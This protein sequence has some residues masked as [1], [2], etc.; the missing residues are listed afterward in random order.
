MSLG[1]SGT[2]ASFLI[3]GNNT[4]DRYSI[5]SDRLPSTRSMPG[6]ALG[7]SRL[8]LTGSPFFPSSLLFT[9][10]KL[11]LRKAEKVAQGQVEPRSPNSGPVLLT[12][13]GSCGSSCLSRVLHEVIVS[14][15]PNGHNACE[16]TLKKRC[17]PGVCHAALITTF[18]SVKQT[19]SQLPW[20]TLVLIK[21]KR[22]D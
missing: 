3:C 19:Q 20:K 9:V 7:R 12:P 13:S 11:N 17:Y 22:I 6:T 21:W 18:S 4:N 10:S 15:K 1:S 14:L 16:N 5:D 8:L 2:S